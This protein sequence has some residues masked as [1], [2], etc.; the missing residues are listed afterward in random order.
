MTDV[1]GHSG[2]GYV[3]FL[4]SPSGYRLQ[5]LEGDPPPAGAELEDNGHELVVTRVGVSPLPGDSRPC[6]YTTGRR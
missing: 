3:L 5:E 2:R 1:N 6:A 4:W